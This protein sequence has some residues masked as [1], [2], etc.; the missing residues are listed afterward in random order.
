MYRH[1]VEEEDPTTKVEN[2]RFVTWRLIHQPAEEVILVEQLKEEITI[3]CR[4]NLL[5]C[6]NS[7]CHIPPF[8]GGAPL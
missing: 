2:G 1:K 3:D 7:H 6:R 5:A 4:K 8:V